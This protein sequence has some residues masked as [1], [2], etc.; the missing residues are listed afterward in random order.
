[1]RKALGSG[2]GW[3]SSPKVAEPIIVRLTATQ[4]WSPPGALI[5]LLNYLTISV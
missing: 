2:A 4:N 3:R 1:M 5:P